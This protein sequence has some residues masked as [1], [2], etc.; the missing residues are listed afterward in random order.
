M[1]K[2]KRSAQKDLASR[3]ILMSYKR[4]QKDS[5]MNLIVKINEFLKKVRVRKSSRDLENQNF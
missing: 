2:R 3:M 1:M 5:R 4:E